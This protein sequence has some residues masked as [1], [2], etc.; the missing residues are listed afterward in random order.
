MQKGK[1]KHP[2]SNLHCFIS[3]HS[4]LEEDPKK[5]I[6]REQFLANRKIKV[7]K[8]GIKKAPPKVSKEFLKNTTPVVEI[9][10]PK[11]EKPVNEKPTSAKNPDVEI[12][13]VP[14]SSE[15]VTEHVTSIQQP[16]PTTN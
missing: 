9:L 3:F 8:K 16:N 10:L 15:N 4:D 1:V 2:G 14:Q 5:M 7:K 6:T 13:E 12:K 11:K